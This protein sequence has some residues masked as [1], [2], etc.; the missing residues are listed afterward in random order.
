M[1]QNKPNAERN[2]KVSKEID[3]DSLV[4]E[5]HCGGCPARWITE[6]KAIEFLDKLIEERKKGKQANNEKVS[7][8][9]SRVWNID[10]PRRALSNHIRGK[11]RCKKNPPTK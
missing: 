6:T 2:L 1:P 10:I 5:C 9:L 4:K 7:E 3:V 8:V 11:C